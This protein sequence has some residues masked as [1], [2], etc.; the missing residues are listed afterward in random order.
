MLHKM[1]ICINITPNLYGPSG[2][3]RYLK[4]L[5]TELLKID[6]EDDFTLFENNSLGRYERQLK[7]PK[8]PNVS[9]VSVR[10]P[11]RLL[12]KLW[13]IW[14]V[15]TIEHFVGEVDVF[16]SPHVVLPPQKKGASVLTVNDMGYEKHPEYYSN[17]ALVDSL[18]RMA[19]EAVEEATRIITISN[20]SKSDLVE[21]MKVPEDEIQVIYDGVDAE[22][23]SSYLETVPPEGE[24]QMLD[25]WGIAEPFLLDVIGT[26]EPRKNLKRLIHAFN[27]FRELTQLDWLLVLVGKIDSCRKEIGGEIKDSKFGS[28]IL[29]LECLPDEDLW[30]LMS[31]AEVFVYPSLYE[32]FGLPV[33]EA[34]ACGTPVVT[35]NVSALP[36][37]AGDAAILAN[38]FEPEE[39]AHAIAEAASDGTLRR[40]LVRKGKQRAK[41]F[42]WRRTA[43]ETLEVYKTAY[44]QKD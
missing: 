29:I 22:M 5:V 35:S 32:G 26:V 13:E 20:A 1:R 6:K 11:M 2:L 17:R 25:K 9:L 31:A 41:S 42:S 24:Q 21:I 3:E 23:I 44:K 14:N 16:H 33:L 38:P 40:E 28:H 39:I 30:S 34:M 15:P 8:S 12:H 37:I 27:I 10:W 43:E 4:H 7:I 18:K 19:R 36:E